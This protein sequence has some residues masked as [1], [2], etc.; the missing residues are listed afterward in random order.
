M[1]G[2]ERESPRAEAGR[3]VHL[4][5]GRRSGRVPAEPYPPAVAG[6]MIEK[7]EEEHK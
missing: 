2:E 3:P 6:T 4:D 7:D 1:N 5:Q